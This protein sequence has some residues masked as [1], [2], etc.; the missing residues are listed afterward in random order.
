[1]IAIYLLGTMQF[2][3]STP[4]EILCYWQPLNIGRFFMEWAKRFVHRVMNVIARFRPR[5]I[6]FPT[7]ADEIKAEQI[8]FFNTVQFSKVW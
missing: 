3:P 5:Y 6:K 1:M 7:L 8:K 2:F 4:L